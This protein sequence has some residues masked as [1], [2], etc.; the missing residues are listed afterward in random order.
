M[1][2]FHN[3]TDEDKET[4]FIYVLRSLSDKP[5]IRSIKN[6]YKIGFSKTSP[7]ERIKNASQDPTYLMAPVS[8]V[9]A[10]KCFNMNPQKLEQLL[11]TFFGSA[12]LNVDVFDGEGKRYIPREWF[13]AP[14]SII[15]QA[16][17][18][19]LDGS[20]VHYQYD[21]EKEGIVE[22]L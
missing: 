16:L 21:P 11:Q 1:D 22:R 9:T 8:I 5:E 6:L 17:Q 4:G 10:F 2:N 3:I 15:E 19:I 20:V 14:I 7:E 12:C 18:L 13:I